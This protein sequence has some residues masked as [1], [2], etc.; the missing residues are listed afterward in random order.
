MK[1]QNKNH[2]TLPLIFASFVFL[3]AA[4]NNSSQ[5]EADNGLIKTE[6][7][8]NEDPLVF[9]DSTIPPSKLLTVGTFH[10]E[11]VNEGLLKGKWL[12]LFKNGSEY[13][14]AEATLK[15]TRVHDAVEDEEK[16][17]GKSGW[18]IETEN[19]DTC[20]FLVTGLD[21]LKA[22][23]VDN[24]PSVKKEIIPGDEVTFTCKGVPYKLVAAGLQNLDSRGE[25][26]N[27]K[28]YLKGSKGNNSVRQLLAAQTDF[29]DQMIQVLFVGDLDGDD[30]PDFLIN[31]SRHYNV[32]KPT[33]YLSKPAE[34]GNVLK[35]VAL[36]ESTGC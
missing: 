13:Y 1:T 7:S 27:Y 31:T 32:Y 17:S 19:K 20:F 33:L 24:V 23:Q 8:S 12:G 25:I 18:K 29:D 14:L 22:G 16:G 6:W 21:F 35:I 5:Q 28:L 34:K 4:C 30:F 2:F 3:L 15:A 36:H 26:T 11:E 10:K 9:P